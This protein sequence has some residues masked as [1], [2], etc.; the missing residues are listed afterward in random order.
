MLFRSF[1]LATSAGAVSYYV[2][3]V[4]GAAKGAGMFR[5]GAGLDRVPAGSLFFVPGAIN[6]R[7][8]HVHVGLLVEDGGE[9][10]VT[11]EGNTNRDGS[12][13]GYEVALRYRRKAGLDFGVIP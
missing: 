7:P 3:W 8:S 9:T 5:P 2:P 10:V 4:V 13:N 12:A 11:I 6:G 1:P